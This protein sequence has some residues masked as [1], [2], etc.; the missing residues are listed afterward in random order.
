MTEGVNAS[1]RRSIGSRHLRSLNPFL[2]L[3]HMITPTTA[4][5]LFPDHPH[6]G[7]ET[8]THLYKGRIRHEDCLGSKGVLYDGD[9]Q[10]MTAGRGIVHSEVP[11]PG[12][13]GLQLWVDLPEAGK[14]VHAKYED[15][16]NRDI[17]R[18]NGVKTLSGMTTTDTVLWDY[19]Y[20]NV[21]EKFEIERKVNPGWT[22]FLY[23]SEG[24]IRIQQSDV[25]KIGQDVDIKKDGTIGEFHLIAYEN[26]TLESTVKLEVPKDQKK[27]RFTIGSGVP[28]DQD[29][30]R[31]MFFV[32][33]SKEGLQKKKEEWRNGEFEGR[34]WNSILSKG[35]QVDFKI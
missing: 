29:I 28:L 6:S 3:D 9:V 34:N 32:A 8:L 35:H 17:P 25:T 4:N 33:T 22:T 26:D 2:L 10:I 18:I 24:R 21:T 14:E 23:I 11:D 12:T 31:N 15:Y 19:V 20:D 27:V 30:F 1:V 16:R 13:E 5:A 7:L